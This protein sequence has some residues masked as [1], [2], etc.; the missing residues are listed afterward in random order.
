MTTYPWLIFSAQTQS[1]QRQV[2]MLAIASG[3]CPPLV[4]DGKLGPSTCGAAKAYAGMNADV[5]TMVKSCKSF[6]DAAA[7]ACKK[8]PWMTRSPD[9]IT[10]QVTFNKLLEKDGFC[11][12][13]TDG[14]LGPTTCA[15]AKK[16]IGAENAGK[17]GCLQYSTLKVCAA[18][19]TPTQAISPPV[20]PS[21]APTPLPAPA[22]AP[23]PVTAEDPR[24]IV[25]TPAPAPAPAPVV[26]QAPPPPSAPKQQAPAPIPRP[27]GG[28]DSGSDW[29]TWAVVGGLALAAGAGTYMLLRK[30]K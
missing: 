29:G 21:P 25:P 5:A 6:N 2:N 22:P 12:I 10:A 24:P 9:T 26:V 17:L 14:V 23:A 1:A 30:K 18:N 19:S 28:G 7:N 20:V 16:V 15:A 8:L 11:A 3:K 27:Q 13:E 4:E